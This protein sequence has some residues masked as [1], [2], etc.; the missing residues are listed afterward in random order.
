MRIGIDFGTTRTVVATSDRGNYPVLPFADANGDFHDYLPSVV[1]L[2]GGRIVCGW[3][4]LRRDNPTLIRS[5]KRMLTGTDVTGDTPVD[6]GDETRPLGE[7][8]T[9]F[10]A[11]VLAEIGEPGE[12][13]EAVIGVPAN[14]NSAQR[15][16]TLDA[17]SRAG[18]DVLGLI[19]EPSAAAFEYSHRH[20]KTL[21]AKRTSIIVYDLGGGTFDATYLRI[22]GAEHEVIA[23]RGI[24]RLGGDDFDE[25]LVDQALEHVDRQDDVFGKRARARMLLEARTAKEALKP[26]SRRIIM[27]L[28]EEDAIVPVTEFYDRTTPLVDQ[29]LDAL[30]PLIGGEDIADGLA[31]TD[32]AGVYLVGGGTSLPLVPRLIKERFGRRV[33][34]SPLP[35]ASTAVGLAIASDPDSGYRLRDLN[36]RGIGVFRERDSGRE[37]SFDPLISP[38]AEP[39]SS[40]TRTYRAAHNIGWMRFVEFIEGQ[41]GRPGDISVLAEVVVPF[42]QELRGVENLEAVPVERLAFP[43]PLV[44]ETVF[45]DQHGIAHVRIEKPEEGWSMEITAES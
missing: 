39:G 20:G 15:L 24:S 44:E 17:F 25:V 28:G 11:E 38:G 8:L 35:T 13:V 27:D 30:E 21:N 26:Q 4:A 6:F 12:T 34:R 3:R 14:A 7:V 37:V 31:D 16:L 43:G 36:S 9:A 29:T 18:A 5:I 32:I 23:T 19:N 1:A 22:D 42:E 2:E 41:D 10:A 33:Y 40:V 45:T